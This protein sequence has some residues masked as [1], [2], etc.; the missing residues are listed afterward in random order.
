MV[1]QVAEG[2][3]FSGEG[4]HGLYLRARAH[5]TRTPMSQG[6]FPYLGNLLSDLLMLQ[7]AMVDYLEVGEPED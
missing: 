2:G 3:D 1:G 5:P 4:L 6:V 7:L